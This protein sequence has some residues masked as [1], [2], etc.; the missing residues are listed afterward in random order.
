MSKDK[1]PIRLEVRDHVAWVTLDRPEKRNTLNMAT[2]DRLIE[3]W[4]ELARDPEVRAVVLTGEGKSF[5]AGLDLNEAAGMFKP[6]TAATRNEFKQ[7]VMRMQEGCSGIEKCFKPVIA[8]VHGHCIGGGIDLITACDIRL[9]SK[10]AVFSVRE[11]R[12]AIVADLG[13]LQRLPSIVGEGR[14]R[15]LCL[16]GRNFTAE[17]AREM[18]LLL[19]VYEDREALREAAGKLAAQ[20]AENPPLAVQG[21]KETLNFSRDHDVYTGLEF[22]ATKSSALLPNED[23]MEAFQAFMQKRKPKFKGR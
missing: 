13:T 1:Q 21:V 9:A 8:A 2:F 5:T 7:E 23:L 20:I 19:E 6:P 12:M 14:A 4:P 10:D 22:V 16:T 15:E 18:G 11:T 3:L 17:E